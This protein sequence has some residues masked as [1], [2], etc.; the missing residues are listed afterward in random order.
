MMEAKLESERFVTER[1]SEKSVHSVKE[2]LGIEHDG[3]GFEY[4]SY[5][6]HRARRGC[7]RRRE[8]GNN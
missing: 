7:A 2:E 6:G 1:R 4:V 5:C 8:G 3:I